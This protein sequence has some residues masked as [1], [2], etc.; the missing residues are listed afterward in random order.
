MSGLDAAVA[1]HRDE[2]HF[3]SYSSFAESSLHR[4]GRPFTFYRRRHLH[5]IYNDPRDLLLK[6]SRQTEKSTTLCN[7]AATALY[8]GSIKEPDGEYRPLRILYF[9]ASWLQVQDFS[10]DRLSR[11]LESPCFVESW[12]GGLP[13]WPKDRNSRSRQYIDQ[14]GEKML[15]NK[16]TWKGRA[17]NQNADRVRGLSVDVIFGDEIQDILHDLFPVIEEAAARSPL[18]KRIYAGTPKTFENA[19]ELRWDESSQNEWMVTCMKC[20]FIQ[21]LT[22]KNIGDKWSMKTESGVVCTHC[23]KLMDPQNG[24]WLAHGDKDASLQGYRIC[25]AMLP[26]DEKGWN[27]LLDKRATYPEQQFHNECLGFSFEHANQVCSKDAVMSCA[28]NSRRNGEWPSE[29]MFTPGL[30]AGIDWGGPGISQTVMTIGFFIDDVYRVVYM[31]NFKD[32]RGTRDEII[33]EIVEILREWDIRF[34]GVDYAVGIKENTD[35]QARVYPHCK[36]IPLMNHGTQRATAVLD[37]KARCYIIN[38]TK[39]LSQIFNLIARKQIQFFC[40]TDMEDFVDGFTYTF[41]DYN[42]KTGALTY[43]HPPNKPDDELHSLNYAYLTS[44]GQFGAFGIKVDA[45]TFIAPV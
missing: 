31:R 39:T 22:E 15:R 28:D 3:L 23:G 33:D 19:I 36:I 14:I 7:K 17:C 5:Q 45:Q 8:G 10:K 40:S 1:G 2:P 11:V 44:A 43:D 4:D 42:S 16:A 35:L 6:C 41:A 34:C 20:G 12:A 37:K 29:W 13:L 30:A 27:D 24:F 18:R 32:F 38:R 25:H 21:M 9:S 26:Q